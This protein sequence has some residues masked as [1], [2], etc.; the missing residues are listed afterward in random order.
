MYYG[1]TVMPPNEMQPRE[2]PK[3]RALV[4]LFPSSIPCPSP[5]LCRRFLSHRQIKKGPWSL[6][7]KAAQAA[8]G[9]DPT[10]RTKVTKGDAE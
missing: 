4:T 9:N 3:G 5:V 6:Y 10:A 8:P 7:A 1:Q 2:V